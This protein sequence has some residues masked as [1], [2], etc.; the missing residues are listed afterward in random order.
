MHRLLLLLQLA[1]PQSTCETASAGPEKREEFEKCHGTTTT[2]GRRAEFWA[3]A[4]LHHSLALRTVSSDSSAVDLQHH[5]ARTEI[6]RR[7]KFTS[8]FARPRGELSREFPTL[9]TYNHWLGV[10]RG[11]M[12]TSSGGCGATKGHFADLN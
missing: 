4:A 5:G 1:G 10:S 7:C 8:F 2:R 9:R 11:T 12:D 6:R 3:G